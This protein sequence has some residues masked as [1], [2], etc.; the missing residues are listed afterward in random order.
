MSAAAADRARVYWALGGLYCL[1][2]AA[3]LAAVPS[4]TF[5]RHA[6]DAGSWINPAY[7]LASGLGFVDP[8]APET[9][10]TE[11]PPGYPAF[12]AAAMTLADDGYP[13]LVVAV[14]LAILLAT[15]ALIARW[16]EEEGA[17][18][19]PLAFGLAAFNP[20]SF[21]AAFYVQ[22]ETLFA[23][24]TAL[25]AYLLIRFARHPGLSLGA[26]LG[27]ALGAAALIRP[28][29]QVLLAAAVL[30]AP[31][32]ALAAR[33]RTPWRRLGA[34]LLV[35]LA[36]G[37]ATTAPWMARNAALG[38]GWR[39]TGQGNTTY[40]LWGA[41]TQLE[42][43]AEGVGGAEAE[44]RMQAAQRRTAEAYEGD[45]AVLS[46][47]ERQVVLRD[48]ALEKILDY[49]VG[50]ILRNV[51]MATLQFLGGGGAGRL[52]ILAGEPQAAPFAFM[53]RTEESDYLDAVTGA[54]QEADAFL[55]LIWVAAL[56]Y[57]AATRI[58]G[59][60]GIYRMV[61]AGRWDLLLLL[62]GAI[63]FFALIFP[64][65]G[66]SRFRLPVE[67]AFVLLAAFGALGGRCGSARSAQA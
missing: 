39:M 15:A 54:L 2:A 65:Y 34:G 29:G 23:L 10:L 32:L 12:V 42:M 16:A 26:G 49:P 50:V 33:G 40:Y 28:E 27:A 47:A 7:G 8:A 21:G 4:E 19:G 11:R 36:V 20:N 37:G 1:I 25:A 63:L 6:A 45:W 3:L 58:L 67:F 66:L 55:I 38:E 46:E 56:S 31:V 44:A 57:V 61:R 59:L 14:Q 52:F 51:T 43:I 17:G 30:G 9:P 62:S 35:C 64:F 18:L 41:A 22:S 48:A 13:A 5:V 24:T 60:V 53:Q